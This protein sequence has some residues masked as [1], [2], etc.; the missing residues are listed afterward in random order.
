MRLVQSWIGIV[1]ADTKINTS[2]LGA[3]LSVQMT[4]SRR[5]APATTEASSG[6]VRRVIRVNE[7][8]TCI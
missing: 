2:G 6:S 8:A 4:M 7:Y 1:K 5:V 3:G